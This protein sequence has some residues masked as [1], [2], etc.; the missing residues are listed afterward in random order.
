MSATND[1]R[2]W[3]T[4]QLANP[5]LRPL[6]R[7]TLGR[8]LGRRLAVLRYHGRRTGRPRELVVQYA[9]EGDQ[10]WILPGESQ[11]KRWWRNMREP[12]PVELW[13]AGRRRTGVAR[14]LGE[15]DRTDELAQALAGYR[16]VFPR[17]AQ[18][19]V[20][21]R[22]DLAPTLGEPHAIGTEADEE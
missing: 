4:N 18:A 20:M 19:T 5:I 16:A 7:G 12:Q 11:R 1:C 13:L 10:V 22:I 3:V 8:R 21:V 14:V 15:G 9:Q 2:F 17:V 6:L